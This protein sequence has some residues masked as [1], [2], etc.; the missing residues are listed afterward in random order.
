MTT[1]VVCKC[2]SKK[3]SVNWDE[4]NPVSTAIELTVPYDQS[5]IYYQLSGGTALTLNTVNKSAADMFELGK[6]YD[7][8]ISPS[9]PE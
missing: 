7:L 5:S 8:L 9:V 3:E 6:D 4:K 2:T 1:K